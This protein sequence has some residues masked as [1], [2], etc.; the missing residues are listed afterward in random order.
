VCEERVEWDRQVAWA[1]VLAG[2]W[3]TVGAGAANR[4]VC[5]C[6]MRE[7]YVVVSRCA[8]VIIIYCVVRQHDVINNNSYSVCKNSIAGGRCYSKQNE[9]T[10]G[11]KVAPAEVATAKA[12]ELPTAAQPSNQA[13]HAPPKITLHVWYNLQGPKSRENATMNSKQLYH[14]PRYG[15][16]PTRSVQ[17]A[18]CSSLQ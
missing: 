2:G 9:T 10:V 6:C 12:T 4:A 8:V 18:R 5:G 15:D 16:S 17:G 11:L 1:W 3:C 14:D 7:L 13:T